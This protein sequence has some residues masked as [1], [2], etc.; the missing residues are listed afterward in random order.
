[1]WWRV[2]NELLGL[3]LLEFLIPTLIFRKDLT[4]YELFLLTGKFNKL[5]NIP[6]PRMVP[7]RYVID[8]QC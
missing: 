6:K 8:E 1:M 3:E 5:E 7:T 4:S 2:A